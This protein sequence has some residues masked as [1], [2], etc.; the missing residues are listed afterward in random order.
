MTIRFYSGSGSPYA[1]RVHLGLEH[2]ALSYETRVLSFSANETQSPEFTALTPRQK[3]PLIDDEGYVLYESA[4][5]MEYLDDAYPGR[6]APLFPGDA[7]QRGTIRRLIC[8]VSSYL[9][10]AADAVIDE[11]LA[12][13]EARDPDKLAKAR[14]AA[15]EEFAFYAKA[16]HGPWLAG[17][18][19]AADFTLYPFVAFMFRLEATRMPELAPSQW[20]APELIAWRSRIEALPWFGRTYP[21]HWRAKAA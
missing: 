6:G 21:P 5:I 1:W 7:A 4:A 17:P 2:K 11:V 18:L 3:V 19:S 9:V 10:P 16:M 20:L 15:R 14:D 13:P 8:E 12:K